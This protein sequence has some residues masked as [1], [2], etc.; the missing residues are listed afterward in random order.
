VDVDLGVGP[1]GTP[2]VVGGDVDGEPRRSLKDRLLGPS[3]EE[4]EGPLGVGAA[5]F[6]PQSAE[7]LL[8]GIT[9]AL[10]MLWADPD[11]PDLWEPT[12][13]ELRQLSAY[14][15]RVA[16]QH[17]RV[18]RA[19]EKGDGLIAAVVLAEYVGRNMGELTAAKQARQER[20]WPDGDQRGE[21]D[22]DAGRGGP[23]APGAADRGHAFR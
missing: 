12:E 8:S 19:I 6:D 2:E 16:T 22:D 5:P 9:G 18:A 17:P 13:D 21:V 1:P 11:V 14:L 20:T 10:A 4:A 23:A 3:A 7:D 15:A